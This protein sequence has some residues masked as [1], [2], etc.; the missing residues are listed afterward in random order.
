MK[1]SR[2]VIGVVTVLLIS[3]AIWA[4]DKK[5]LS[6]SELGKYVISAKAGVVNIIEGD[7]NVARSLPFAA[8]E[9]PRTLISG[10]ELNSGDVVNTGA[11]GRVEI[12]LDPGCYLRLGEQSRFVFLF[13]NIGTAKLK[14]TR[15]SAVLEASSVEN[16]IFIETPK[17]TLQIIREGLYRFNVDSDGKA[18]VAVRKGRALV[19]ATTIKEGKRALVDSDVG[20]IAKL[21][22]KDVDDLDG[23]SKDRARSLIAANSRLSNSGL[24]RTF[25]RSSLWYNAWV[26]DPFFHCYTFLPYSSG[27]AS[28]Y[29]WDYAV[30]NPF[31]A[32][33]YYYPRRNN[34]GSGPNSGSGSNSG[35]GTQAGSGSQAGGGS[36]AGGGTTGGGSRAGGGGQTGGPSLGGGSM[37]MPSPPSF[38]GSAD[39]GAA[40]GSAGPSKGRSN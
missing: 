27:F 24:R 20:V 21:D 25:N 38:G 18:E 29:G 10:D 7:V 33:N 11:T 30:L 16:P 36:R 8:P 39:R 5:A 9:A 26:Y 3:T 22:K 37:R 19:G 15:G 31:W 1:V 23:W 17:N 14:L 6:R 2:I 12:L 4:Q 35:G 32:Y 34:N 40:R 28:P 13:D